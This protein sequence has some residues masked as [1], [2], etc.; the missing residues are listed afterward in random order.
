MEIYVIYNGVVSPILLD[1]N[2]EEHLQVVPAEVNYVNFTWKAGNR[3][4]FYNFN[5][6]KS[7]NEVILRPPLISIKTDGKIPKRPKEFSVFLTCRENSSGNAT[8][9]ISLLIE[10]RRRKRLP[11][12]PLRL[13]LKKECVRRGL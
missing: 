5:R 2:F 13:K 9:D 7:F 10:N 8:F 6:L 1:P 12:T 4:Y 3:K 11:G